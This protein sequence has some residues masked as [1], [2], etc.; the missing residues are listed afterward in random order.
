MKVRPLPNY[1][2]FNYQ[3]GLQILT[4][5]TSTRLELKLYSALVPAGFPSPADDH[6]DRKLDLNDHLITNPDATFFVRVSG[7]SMVD[8]NIND[9]DVLIVDRSLQAKDGD[10]I[11][12]VVDG[13]FTVKC[14]SKQGD[15]IIL[16]PANKKYKPTEIK[17]GMDFRVWGVVT[18]TIHK[19]K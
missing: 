3:N 9:G 2:I 11:I 17:E 10:I 14:L 15:R 16:Q 7:D 12:G 6:L 18:Y 19:N 1:Y 8:C 13:E 5:D 4:P